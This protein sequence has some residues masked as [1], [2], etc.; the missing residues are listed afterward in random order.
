MNE[1]VKAHHYG[2]T[3]RRIVNQSTVYHLRVVRPNTDHLTN[4]YMSEHRVGLLH[5]VDLANPA[6][7]LCGRDAEGW[8]M[9]CRDAARNARSGW[10]TEIDVNERD[11]CKICVR[12]FWIE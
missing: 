5:I 11:F 12:R 1:T 10:V 3:G 2:Q 8:D 9:P 6:R 4:E 7:A